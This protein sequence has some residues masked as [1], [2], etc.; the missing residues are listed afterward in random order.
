VQRDSRERVEWDWDVMQ[1][2]LEPVSL[3]ETLSFSIVSSMHVATVPYLQFI[4][5]F[6]FKK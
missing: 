1:V 6:L 2:G 5:G 3:Q 4:V